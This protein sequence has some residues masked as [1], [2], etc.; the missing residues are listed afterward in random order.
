[1]LALAGRHR[2]HR[3][4]PVVTVTRCMMQYVETL[5]CRHYVP[6]GFVRQCSS[7]PWVL[8]CPSVH[9]PQEAVA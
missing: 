8:R 2:R 1:M 7:K 6:L 3:M 9:V 5:F 4:V